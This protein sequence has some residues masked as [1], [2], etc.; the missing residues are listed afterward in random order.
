MLGTQLLTIVAWAQGGLNP[1]A[2]GL[3]GLPCAGIV[4][5]AVSTALPSALT[6][7][8]T[9]TIGTIGG[10]SLPLIPFG[11]FVSPSTAIENDIK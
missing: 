6:V 10:T 1:G 2:L 9:D 3:R 8:H 7:G 4:A 11:S 5:V